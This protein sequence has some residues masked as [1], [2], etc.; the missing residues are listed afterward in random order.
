MKGLQK[1][2]HRVGMHL[3]YKMPLILTILGSAGVVVTVVSA[4]RAT[5]KALKSIDE[6]KE[7]KG[8]ELTTMEKVQ[9]AAPAYIGTAIMG[10]STIACIFGANALNMRTQASIASAYALIDNYHKEYRKTLIDLHGKEIDEEVRNTMARE[11]CD[12]HV[13][14]NDC[15]DSK[16]LFYDEISGETIARYERDVI[17]AEY[18]FNRNFV[19]R[20]Y[21]CLNELY[22][23]LGIPQTEYGESV[24]WTMSSGISWVDFEHRLIEKD[25]GGTPVY[26]IDMVFAPGSDYMDDW[27]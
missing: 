19:L 14:D 21:A 27:L 5:P 6:A 13:I 9:A 1:T 12:Y 16:V 4:V 18:H 26:A 24:G 7:E 25:D 20:G 3:H 17:D 15:P 10:A 22:E 2:C 11:H 8:E 23:F